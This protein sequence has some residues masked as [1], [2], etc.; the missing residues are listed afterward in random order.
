MHQELNLFDN[1]D[2][3]ANVYLRPR[4]VSA[5]AAASRRPNARSKRRRTPLLKRL[6]ADFRSGTPVADLSLAQRQLVEIAK[7]MSLDARVVIMDEPTSSLT[8]A[9]TDRLLDVVADL[10]ANGV[11]V[12]FI[13]HRLN[14]IERCADRVVVLRDGAVVGELGRGEIEHD[15]M[16]RLMI[17][18]DLKSLYTPPAAPAGAEALVL[19][20]LRRRPVPAVPS[21]LALRPAKSSAWPGWSARDAPNSRATIFGIDRPLCRH[22]HAATARAVDDPLA[23]RRHRRRHLSRARRTASARA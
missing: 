18:R 22:D 23:A 6:G 17:G 20:G 7:A 4:A 19:A 10:K 3:A 1:L 5:R 21:S 2:V 13:T 16:I 14:E 9:E 11:C 15:A 12:I 8:V